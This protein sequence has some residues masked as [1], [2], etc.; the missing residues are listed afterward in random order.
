MARCALRAT[1]RSSIRRG[2]PLGWQDA[3]LFLSAGAAIRQTSPFATAL[4]RPRALPIKLWRAIFLRRSQRYNR[5]RG[6]ETNQEAA[7][8]GSLPGLLGTFLLRCVIPHSG[9]LETCRREAAAE[10]NSARDGPIQLD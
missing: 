5:G 6:F 3:L 10:E 8:T 9:D 7:G 4:T 2:K 1:S